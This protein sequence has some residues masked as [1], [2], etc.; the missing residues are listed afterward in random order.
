VW[1]LPEVDICDVDSV[2]GAAA[3]LEVD[4]LINAAAIDFPPGASDENFLD[5]LDCN[6]KG[7][8]NCCMALMPNMED[9]AVINISS[10]YGLVAP[11]WNK[12]LA[13]GA[14]KAAIIQMTKHLA[15][16]FPH[17]RVN[18]VSF[19]GVE[20]DQPDWFK[21][22]YAGRCP[23]GRMAGI[24]EYDDVILFMLTTTY[25]TGSNLVVDGGWTAM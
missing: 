23:I 12:P 25:M 24:H 1:D 6:I 10:I 9:G 17:L 4:G 16:F 15:V 3:G 19:G 18:S 8:Y 22:E 7:T 11:F 21:E 13:Y 14:S 5:V 20:G 2:A